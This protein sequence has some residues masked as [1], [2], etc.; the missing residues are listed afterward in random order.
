MV[1][2]IIKLA[3]EILVFLP[4]LAYDS[5]VEMLLLFKLKY[6]LHKSRAIQAHIVC[7]E[8]I[9][10]NIDYSIPSKDL[11]DNSFTRKHW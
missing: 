4:F 8:H 6:F 10:C 2:C 11:S 9:L 1:P 3:I 5:N 7:L